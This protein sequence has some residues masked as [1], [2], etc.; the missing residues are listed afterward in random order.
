MRRDILYIAGVLNNNRNI[1]P[2]ILVALLL[3]A[4]APDVVQHNNTGNE[5]FA[6]GA[7]GE[8]LAEYRH[9]Q[10][11]DPDRAEPYYNAANVYNREAQ[12]EKTLAQAQQALKT[13]DPNLA[14]QIWYNLGNAYFDAAKWSE[15]ITAYQEALRINADDLDAKH[16]LELALQKLDDQ[17][18]QEQ[19]QQQ[20][21]QEPK[22]SDDQS[23]A[24]EA[25]PTPVGQPATPQDSDQERPTPSGA[26]QETKSS[27]TPEQARQLLQAVIGHSETLQERL[28]EIHQVPGLPPARDW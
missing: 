5:R 23:Q 13:A 27:I 19:Q 21:N 10:L 4:C 9:A 8:A 1:V 17:Q 16:N 6:Q 15:A 24:G 26:A 25:T 18:Q 3:G 2:I 22:T 14:T 11:D 28:R 20:Q 7:F 12:L